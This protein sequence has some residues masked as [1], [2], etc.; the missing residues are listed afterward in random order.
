MR[1]RGPLV[2]GQNPLHPK[3]IRLFDERAGFAAVTNDP[4]YGFNTSRSGLQVIGNGRPE[5]S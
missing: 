2:V 1:G 3:L 5:E 4:F